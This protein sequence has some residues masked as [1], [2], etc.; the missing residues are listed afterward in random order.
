M[1]F[2]IFLK[3]YDD[4]MY[5]GHL[6]DEK[7]FE[8]RSLQYLEIDDYPLHVYDAQQSGDPEMFKYKKELHSQQEKTDSAIEKFYTFAEKLT[9]TDDADFLLAV[10]KLDFSSLFLRQACLVLGMNMPDGDV[11]KDDIKKL[12]RLSGEYRSADIISAHIQ[13]GDDADLYD[14]LSEEDK[15]ERVIVSEV[16][17]IVRDIYC[18]H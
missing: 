15:F 16:M 10:A 14:I 7:E 2:K 6:Y 1:K 5:L 18:A 3:D 13:F 17:D 11:T 4:F 9:G 12:S 8:K